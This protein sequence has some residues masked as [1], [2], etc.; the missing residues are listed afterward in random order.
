MK[1]IIINGFI[2]LAGLFCMTISAQAS[3]VGIWGEHSYG[4]NQSAMNTFY[5]SLS[6]TTSSIL[7]GTLDTNDLSGTDLLWAT[8]PVDP[9]TSA[10]ISTMNAFLANG[11]RIAFMGEH[12]G[13]LGVN[14][15][16]NITSAIA[17]LGGHMSIVNHNL[18]DPGFHDATRLNGQILNHTLTA[19]VDKYTYAAFANILMSGPAQALMLGSNLTTTM[20]AY[21]NI[22]PGSI[23]LI[24]D[25][26][27]WDLNARLGSN[28][29]VLFEN[30]L[31]AK[32][33]A[34]GAP[35]VPEPATMLLFGTGMVGAFIKKRRI[36]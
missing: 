36:A 27:V 35:V 15:N 30:L 10:E 2:V 28:N 19:G 12:G 20:M 8:Q 34:P 25:Q 1:K 26:N 23:F 6:G 13:G 11:G 18:I 21:E 32:T 3:V 31:L 14:E 7:T 16:N 17:S 5:N 29:D 33:G 22:G 9:Y 24:T 4:L